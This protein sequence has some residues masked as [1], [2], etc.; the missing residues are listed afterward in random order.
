MEHFN[1]SD[2]KY[3]DLAIAM[4]KMGWGATNPNPLVGAVVVKDDLVIG[5]G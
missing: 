4:A 1:L 2:R 5:R 3:M